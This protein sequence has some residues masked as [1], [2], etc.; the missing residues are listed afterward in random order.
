MIRPI[1]LMAAFLSTASAAA[2]PPVSNTQTSLTLLF[3]NNLNLTDNANHVGALLLDSMPY[4]K[5]AS[6]C[7]LVHET[8]VTKAIIQAHADDF[9]AQLAYASNVAYA[10]GWSYYIRDGI[11]E[12]SEDSPFKF[13]PLPAYG[14]KPLPVLC[15][16]S[17]SNVATPAN[18]ITVSASGNTYT[19]FRNQKSFRF[20]GIPYGDFKERFTHSK[21]LTATGVNYNATVAGPQCFQYGSGA[22]H[23]L[24]LNVYTPYI[25]KSG[26]RA[27]LRPVHFWIHGGGFEGG[28]GSDFDGGE[29]ASREDVVTVTFNYRLGA[30]GFMTIPGVL[31]G[32][33]GIGDQIVALD[34]TIKNIAKFGGDPDAITINGGSA[35]A[36]SV[37]ALL[38]SPKAIGKFAAAIAMS[39]LG[40]GQAFGSSGDYSTAFT[41]YYTIE[42]AFEV[43]GRGVLT[44]AGCNQTTSAEQVKC[45]RSYQGAIS[46]Q[47]RYVVQDGSIVVTPRLE[48]AKRTKNT[49]HVPVIFGIITNDGASFNRYNKTCTSKVE[50]IAAD[51][52]LSTEWAQEVLDSGLFPYYP[53]GDLFADT[54]NVTQRIITDTMFRCIDQAGIYAAAKSKAF[55]KAYYYEAMRGYAPPSYNPNGADIT[56]PITPGYPYGNPNLPHYK[57]HGGDTNNVF[58]GLSP[59]RDENDLK[60][61]QLGMAYYGAFIRSSGNPNPEVWYLKARQYDDV[62]KAVRETGKWETVKGEQGPIAL[63]DYPTRFGAFVDVP[64]CKWLNY[65][66]EYN[67]VG[68]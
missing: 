46:S 25:P 16:Q 55:S 26:S 56:G 24:F 63:L 67:F 59:L 1:L 11:V 13:K 28:K 42:E 38:G 6:A 50:C 61:I 35:G 15:T 60:T 12:V 48:V 20:L 7:A 44:A 41:D 4:P 32:N 27:K 10:K 5:A 8:L 14:R 40:G 9:R 29:L 57:L 64:Q 21:L 54:Y 49:A 37:R 51:A 23:C 68:R 53:T 62:L 66:L 17:G 30:Y 2:L 43:S 47:A 3:Q 34:W 58:G 36:A 18:T 19:G 45:L 31:N 22:E 65:S 52:F 33:Y 39:N